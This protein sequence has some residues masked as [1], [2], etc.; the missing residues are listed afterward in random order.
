MI[1]GCLARIDACSFA[2][3]WVTRLVLRWRPAVDP[4]LGLTFGSARVVPEVGTVLICARA[5]QPEIALFAQCLLAKPASRSRRGVL[6]QECQACRS[7]RL[8]L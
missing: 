6:G 5:V 3:I 7:R 4:A 2:V 8:A 1:I